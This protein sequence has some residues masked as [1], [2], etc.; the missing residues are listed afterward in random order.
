MRALVLVAALC[1]LL[2]APSVAGRAVHGSRHPDP[3]RD[4][5]KRHDRPGRRRRL[6]ARLARRQDRRAAPDRDGEGAHGRRRE[7]TRLARAAP[8]ARRSASGRRCSSSSA[9]SSGSGATGWPRRRTGPGARSPGSD[10]VFQLYAGNGWQLQPLANMGT[11]NALSQAAPDH[12][13]DAH[14]GRRPAAARG[15][16]TAGRCGSSTYFPWSGGEPGWVSAM[17]QA[18]ALEAYAR[19]GM[20]AEAREMLQVFHQDAAARRPLRDRARAGALPHVPAGPAPADRQRIRPGR[21][22]AAGVRRARATD[23]AA[24]AA[25]EQALAEAR[26]DM[27]TVRHRRLVALLPRARL[28]EGRGV[29]PALPPPVQGLP[30]RAV[31]PDRRR[32]VLHDGGELRPLR[33]RAGALRDAADRADEDAHPGAGL[34]VEALLDQGDAL[35]RRRGGRRARRSAGGAARSA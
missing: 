8:A 28:A 11:L 33:D 17:P 7:N 14:V 9:T 23:P 4:R 35:P 13:E 32:A 2:V 5:G 22:L 25:Y 31:R 6:A 18:V 16:A 19:L 15:A 27:T 29:R 12:R 10:V 3:R 20:L 34:R 1:A 26:A 30:R 24:Q 21:D